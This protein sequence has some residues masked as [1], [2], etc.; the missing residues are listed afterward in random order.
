M[1]I[2]LLKE[3]VLNYGMHIILS[4]PTPKKEAVMDACRENGNGY[5]G[6][7]PDYVKMKLHMQ[8]LKVRLRSEIVN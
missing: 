8:C 6:T 1:V 5:D 4:Q 2:K 3:R 7:S